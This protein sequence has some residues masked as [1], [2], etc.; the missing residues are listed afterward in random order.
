MFECHKLPQMGDGLAMPSIHSAI[1]SGSKRRRGDK[2]GTVADAVSLRRKMK[3]TC[4]ALYTKRL[5]ESKPLRPHKTYQVGPDCSV[6]SP[7]YVLKV[8]F[9]ILLEPTRTDIGLSMMC[10]H[11]SIYRAVPLEY[12]ATSTLARYHT[13]SSCAHAEF[14]S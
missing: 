12:L 8:S 14:T 6:Y 4:A 9:F 2:H 13:Q 1:L 5:F 11:W 10:T 7:Y 3:G